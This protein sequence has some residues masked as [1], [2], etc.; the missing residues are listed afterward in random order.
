[1]SQGI[2]GGPQGQ[3][4]EE[5]KKGIGRT[6]Q[7]LVELAKKFKCDKYYSH[8]YVE[9]AYGELFHGMNVRRILEIGI[10]FFDL[11]KDFVPEYVHGASL[12]MWEEYWPDAAVFGADIREDTLVN[13]GR[14]RSFVVDQRS[15]ESLMDLFEKCGLQKFDVVIDDGS[16]QTNDQIISIHTLLSEVRTGGLWI[17]EDVN[18]PDLLLANIISKRRFLDYES[19]EVMR[20]GKRPDDNLLVIR[21]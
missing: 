19:A 20:F 2:V 11:M 4:N 17:T 16:H 6:T 8:S 3:N 1:M 5:I 12:K 10:G 7:R 18:Q 14:I 9:L 21:K 15:P 13:E